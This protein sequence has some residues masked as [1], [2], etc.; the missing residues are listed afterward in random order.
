[1]KKTSVHNKLTFFQRYSEVPYK[2]NDYWE[3]E[4]K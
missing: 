1:M 4:K 3:P 2:E